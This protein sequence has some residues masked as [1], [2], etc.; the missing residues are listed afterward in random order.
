MTRP[1]LAAVPESPPFVY[2]IPRHERLDG[3]TFVKWW[4]HRWLA[5]DLCLMGTFEVKGMARDLFD[6]AQT[7]SPMGTLPRNLAVVARLLR[8]D[9]QH[10]EGLC[11]LTYGPMS[12][13]QPCVTEDGEARL[14][15]PVVLEQVQDAL[16]RREAW[17]A[18][19]SAAAVRERQR[20]LTAALRDLGVK[21][22]V[23]ADQAL[24]D[25]MDQWLVDNWKTKRTAEAYH[26]VMVAAM[27]GGWFGRAAFENKG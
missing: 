27:E 17:I 15:H 10:F 6:L 20:R 24:V 7:Q 12:G 25:R 1:V 18:T 22:Q 19:N 14:Y 26:K 4:H 11:R 16:A 13:W 5:S 23:L 3:Q 2:P 8:V 21:A 9:V